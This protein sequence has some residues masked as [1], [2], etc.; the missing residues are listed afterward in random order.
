MIMNDRPP[1]KPPLKK[2]GLPQRKAVDVSAGELVAME[3]LRP[4]HLLPLVVRPALP[5][6]DLIEWSSGHRELI[7]EKLLAH[8]GILFRGFTMRS[9][10]SFE[11][12][13]GTVSG[14]LLQYT[15]RSTPRSEVEGRIYTST[16]YP[17]DQSIPLH[18][19]M[20]YSRAWPLKIWFYCFQAAESGGETP[21]ADSRRI[22]QRLDPALR[23]R[24][25]E[26]GVMY[27]RNYGGGL[28]LSWQNVF[29]TGDPAEVEA[30]CRQQ[31]IECEWLENGAL[32]TRQ[33]CQATAVHPVT[34]EPVW[35]N[36]AHLFHVSSLDPELRQS[37]IEDLTEE[38]LPRNA[39]FGDGSPIGDA[40][41]AAIRAVLAEESVVFPWE[42]GDIVLLDNML[43]AHG[44][45]PFR[46]PRRVLV[47]MAEEIRAQAAVPGLSE[48]HSP[49]LAR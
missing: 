7:G 28:D 6:V 42:Q 14:D 26:Q 3:P 25:E 18:N 1:A 12:L 30:F 2:L 15:Y 24:F 43:A 36:Q 20:S 40:D 21:I 27:V 9:I 35:F 34:G 38:G 8:G 39:L 5:G 10:S 23:R 45:R 22:F 13:V 41:L 37:L 48:N 32:R 19:E 46:G 29:G 11:K 17:P 33:V 44:R 47:G 16:E 31:G 4:G 49:G